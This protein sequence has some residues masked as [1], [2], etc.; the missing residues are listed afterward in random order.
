MCVQEL[1]SANINALFVA[2]K[3]RFVKGQT[4]R[5]AKP[6]ER[7]TASPRLASEALLFEVGAI[8][9]IGCADPIPHFYAGEK[10]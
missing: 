1:V 9:R 4:H 3:Y 10:I 7:S 8:C 6:S 5:T 2:G